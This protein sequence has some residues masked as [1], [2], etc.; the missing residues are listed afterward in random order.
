[1]RTISI[2]AVAA[3]FSAPAK[4]EAAPAIYEKCDTVYS[5]FNYKD[6]E[7]YW[8][9]I[10]V[11]NW[12]AND[13]IWT[14]TGGTYN[15]TLTGTAFDKSGHAGVGYAI[16]PIIDL[17]N[18]STAYV[19][20]N[21]AA[22]YQKT[23]RDL[24]KFCVWVEGSAEE[25]YLEIPNWTSG[26]AWKWCNSGYIDVSEFCGKKVQFGFRYESVEG[27]NDSWQLNTFV[28]TTSVPQLASDIIYAGLP[29]DSWVGYYE[30][31]VINLMATDGGADVWSSYCN[32][33]GFF[34]R[35]TAYTD[36]SHEALA[37]FRSPE[38]DLTGV[39]QCSVSFDHAARY[40]TTIRSLCKACVWL[41][42]NL[43]QPILLD[44]PVWPEAGG[45]GYVN[46]GKIDLTPYC[47]HKIRFG[48]RYK[49]T[50]AGADTWNLRNVVVRNEGSAAVNTVNAE[51]AA[52]NREVYDLNGVKTD[53]EAVAPGYYIVKEG[54]AVS[55]QLLR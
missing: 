29:A 50:D 18:L 30:W 3:L 53:A 11:V 7:C 5:C 21:H 17:G 6:Q 40:Q 4:A 20:F 1:M 25:K 38:I 51:S 35:G 34:A 41:D 39:E 23:L 9:C 48:F 16:S 45:W 22:K 26:G 52:A 2:L 47:G 10:D 13:S 32:D 37:Y 44:I 43:D 14:W 24:C 49:S 27:G 31:D 8:R 33:M 19:S 15:H 55:K 42:D 12:S 54:D 46:S 36:A 28:V